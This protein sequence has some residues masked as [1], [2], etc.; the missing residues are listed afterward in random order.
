MIKLHHND[1]NDSELQALLQ[2]RHYESPQP[3]FAA[4]I[5]AGAYG[6]RQKSQVTLLEWLTELL[7]DYHMPR[8]AF[9]M[10]SLLLT[11]YLLGFSGIMD[12]QGGMEDAGVT[13]EEETSYVQAFLY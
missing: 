3:D 2:Q 13:M 8:P 11:G 5:I 7:A 10:S 4:R 12:M 6:L 9:M 1:D